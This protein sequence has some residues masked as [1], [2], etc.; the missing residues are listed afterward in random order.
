M[1]SLTKAANDPF[2]SL[3]KSENALKTRKMDWYMIYSIPVIKA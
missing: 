1:D 2:R 3:H